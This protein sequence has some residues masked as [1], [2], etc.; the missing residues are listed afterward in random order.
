M[1]ETEIFSTELG[2]TLT[3]MERATRARVRALRILTAGGPMPA[4]TFSRRM[5]PG[6]ELPRICAYGYLGKLRK[7]GLVSR[8]A[9]DQFSVTAN[10]ISNLKV[11]APTW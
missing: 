11:W 9:M 5:W 3:P 4:P 8:S 1:A 6:P 10:G 7:L 2:L